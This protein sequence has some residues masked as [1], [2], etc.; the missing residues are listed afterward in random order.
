MTLLRTPLFTWSIVV[1]GGLTLLATPVLVGRLIEGYIGHHFG[2]VDATVA[3]TAW[4]WSVPQVYVLAVP[5]AGVAAEI[6]PVLSRSRHRAH[7]AVVVVLALLGVLGYGAWAQLPERTDELLYVGMALAALLPA[8][9]L[10]AILGDA[11]R[12]GRPSLGAANLLAI[13][14][15]VQLLLGALAGA[16]AAIDPLELQGTTW[17]AAQVHYTLYGAATMGAFAALWFWAPKIWGVLLGE[18]Q[19]KAVFALTFLG[20]I[21]LSAP[22]LV[23]GLLED[24]LR[25]AT[26]FDDDGLTVAMNVLSLVGGVLAILGVLAVAAELVTKVGRRS[27]TPAADDPWGGSTLEWSTTSPPPAGNF[28]GP[29]PVVTSATPLLDARTGTE[30]DA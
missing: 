19:G 26:T 16:A 6:I 1:G 4:F 5:A 3:G 22:D 13:G 30:V 17:Q 27:G 12:R 15:A 25:G 7:A 29:V 11:L 20:A 21:L 18:A 28:T 23:S 10:L 9:A 8:L 14:A 24:Q 2:G